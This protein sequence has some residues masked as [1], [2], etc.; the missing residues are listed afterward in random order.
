MLLRSP[1]G[2]ASRRSS[3]TRPP[4]TSRTVSRRQSSSAQSHRPISG[5]SA[6]MGTRTSSSRASGG[7][8]LAALLLGHE[9]APVR[10]TLLGQCVDRVV[11]R[12]L[13]RESVGVVVL[14]AG[15]VVLLPVRD[16]LHV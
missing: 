15:P 3:L 9:L 7:L 16:A 6:P 11:V 13:P 12:V 1:S 10:L 8:E 2:T 4:S 5:S 14:D